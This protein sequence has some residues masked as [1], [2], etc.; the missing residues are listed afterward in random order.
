MLEKHI[1]KDEGF[2]SIFHKHLGKRKCERIYL[3]STEVIVA[4]PM[5]LCNLYCGLMWD[6]RSCEDVYKIIQDHPRSLSNIKESSCK[7]EKVYPAKTFAKEAKYV[8]CLSSTGCI[9]LVK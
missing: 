3:L 5:V 4:L 9:W 6:F 2:R 7:P 8:K 1:S